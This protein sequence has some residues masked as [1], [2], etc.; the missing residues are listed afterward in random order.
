[1]EVSKGRFGQAPEFMYT[2]LLDEGLIFCFVA[3]LPGRHGP[4]WERAGRQQETTV[5]QKLVPGNKQM[6]F[7]QFIYLFFVMQLFL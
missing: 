6:Q 3:T 1:M 5:M 2:G 4:L 7:E